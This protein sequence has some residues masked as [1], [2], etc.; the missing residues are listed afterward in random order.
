MTKSQIQINDNLGV[1]GKEIKDQGIK[2]LKRTELLIGD[3]YAAQ[4]GPSKLTSAN[5]TTMGD[6]NNPKS[7]TGI[8]T[9]SSWRIGEVIA[10]KQLK[11]FLNESK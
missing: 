8:I 1:T 10:Q 6:T 3:T 5:T 9:T 7:S 4:S 11:D 2:R